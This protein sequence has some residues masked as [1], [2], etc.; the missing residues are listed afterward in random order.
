MNLC[1]S[2]RKPASVRVAPRVNKD[3]VKHNLC[4]NKRFFLSVTDAE[5]KGEAHW[6]IIG[7]RS[8]RERVITGVINGL[9]N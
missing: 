5:L 4:S 7:P 8:Y 9:S 2:V 3:A 6:L 1:F